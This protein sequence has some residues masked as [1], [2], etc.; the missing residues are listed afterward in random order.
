MNFIK[1]FLLS[2]C[3]LFTACATPTQET[4]L[5]FNETSSDVHRGADAQ[6][7][8]QRFSLADVQIDLSK[9]E[10]IQ[11]TENAMENEDAVTIYAINSAL[12]GAEKETQLLDVKF[13]M[14]DEPVENGS[15]IFGIETP[16]DNQLELQML[17]EEGYLMVANNSFTINKGENY[18][19]LDVKSL[20][21]GHYVFRLIDKNGFELTKTV[22]IGK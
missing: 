3:L 6:H 10:T 4:S 20:A 14:S 12:L 15:F 13:S 19:A 11:L 22:T 16:I 17:D 2:L 18:K 9:I 21:N 8:I 5:A 7:S 1:L